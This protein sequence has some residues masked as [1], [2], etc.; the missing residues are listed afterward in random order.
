MRNFVT[1][2]LM[3]ESTTDKPLI[4]PYLAVLVG[5]LAVSFSSLF[6]KLSSAPSIVIATYRLLF[7]FLI[8]A[9]FTV[10]VKRSDLKSMSQ[11]EILMA[12]GSGIFLAMHFF[13]WFT[14]LKYTSVASSTVLVTTQPI[15]VV[16]GSYLFFK[17]KVTARAM[18][19]GALALTGSV[20]VGASDFRVGPDALFGD[21]LALV[22]AVL[23]S[24]YLIIGRRLRSIVS[25]SAYTFV[26]YGSASLTLVLI[27]LVSRTPFFPYPLKDWL[28]FL[29]LAVVCTILGHT[30]FNWA[31]RY[32]PASVIAVSVLGEP[33]GAIIWALVFLAEIPTPRQIFGGAVILIGI[34]IFTRSSRK[35]PAREIQSNFH[36]GLH[37]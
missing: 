14:S 24:G 1:R 3:P 16:L 4:N 19:G 20:I 33:I 2:N 26:T 13:T 18:L 27:S 10:T 17:E 29:A 35:P 23:V 12:A 11:K 30:S 8:L 28:T 6:V 9:P 21:V 31:L 36:I 15:F 22:A 34:Y 25:L 32:I 37:Q 5:V 7:S